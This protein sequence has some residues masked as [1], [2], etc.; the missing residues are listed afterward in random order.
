MAIPVRSGYGKAEKTEPASGK[1]LAGSE[2]RGILFINHMDS[3]GI[4]DM[5]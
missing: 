2:R 5:A 4:L 3:K 1:S